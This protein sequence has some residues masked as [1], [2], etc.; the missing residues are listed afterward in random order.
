V[1]SD[2][3]NTCHY[4]H[5]TLQYYHRVDRP[6]GARNGRATVQVLVSAKFCSGEH[7]MTDAFVV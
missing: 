2:Y 4:I 3:K 1:T 7:K 5:S 6:T